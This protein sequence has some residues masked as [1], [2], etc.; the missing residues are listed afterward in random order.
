VPL[1]T[2]SPTRR[3][4]SCSEGEGG[5]YSLPS[6]VYFSRWRG[7]SVTGSKPPDLTAPIVHTSPESQPT[8][9]VRFSLR[10][11]TCFGIKRQRCVAQSAAYAKRAGSVAAPRR[12]ARRGAPCRFR[13]PCEK[14][15][16]REGCFKFQ[17]P[18]PS[19]RFVYRWGRRGRRPITTS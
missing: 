3:S 18:I 10:R 7:R 2:N 8:A 4:A 1:G 15:P 5:R 6:A 13:R 19:D 9:I 17:T 12:R 14:R 11:S 16:R